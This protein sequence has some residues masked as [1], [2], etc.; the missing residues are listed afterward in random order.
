M[1]ICV[2]PMSYAVLR[3]TPSYVAGQRGHGIAYIGWEGSVQ[4]WELLTL[5]ANPSLLLNHRGT[6]KTYTDNI[7]THLLGV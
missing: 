3:W 5:L 7:H 2:C 1:L 4:H 6:S